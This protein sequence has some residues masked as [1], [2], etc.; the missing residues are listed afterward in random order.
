M[1]FTPPLPPHIQNVHAQ[2]AAMQQQMENNSWIQQPMRP[3][4]ASY[5][6]PDLRTSILG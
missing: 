6:N 5:I 4:S 3:L 1:Q 2:M